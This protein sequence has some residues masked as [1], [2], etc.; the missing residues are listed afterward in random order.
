VAAYRRG[1]FLSPPSPAIA[2]NSAAVTGVT[3]RRLPGRRMSMSLSAAE[4]RRSGRLTSRL[5][6][7][8]KETSMQLQRGFYMVD[9][10]T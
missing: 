10:A 4:S 7:W 9:I 6:P 5:K 2:L 1:Y 8:W 3:E